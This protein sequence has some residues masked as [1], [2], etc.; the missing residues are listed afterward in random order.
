MCPV[1]CR[2]LKVHFSNLSEVV[3]IISI[4]IGEYQVLVKL[5]NSGSHRPMWQ[6]QYSY[7]GLV[8]LGHCLDTLAL[9]GPGDFL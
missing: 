4:F 2:L 3:I 5:R 7:L 8:S 1:L 9:P 6:K